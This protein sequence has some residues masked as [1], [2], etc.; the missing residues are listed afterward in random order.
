MFG[1]NYSVCG[2]FFNLSFLFFFLWAIVLF[3]AST[4]ICY[5]LYF[6]LCVLLR[7][8]VCDGFLGFLGREA[9]D[10]LLFLRFIRERE[11]FGIF[12]FLNIWQVCEWLFLSFLALE[13]SYIYVLCYKLQKLESYWNCCLFEFL[14]KMAIYFYIYFNFFLLK[15]KIIILFLFQ[16]Q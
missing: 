10:L 4:L 16:R 15:L 7:C 11:G 9:I 6:S 8:N 14:D 2:F 12:L 5:V 3:M 13:F 1:F